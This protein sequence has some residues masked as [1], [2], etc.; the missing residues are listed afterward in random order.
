M[1]VIY[2]DAKR[3]ADPAIRSTDKL[4]H[5]PTVPSFDVE[6]PALQYIAF[7]AKHG[8]FKDALVAR[9]DALFTKSAT[10]SI[11]NASACHMKSLTP[12]RL[13]LPHDIAIIQALQCQ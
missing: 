4:C 6:D 10:E 9:W 3:R 11:V 5:A 12:L 2:T 13:Q 1:M 7:M 8:P